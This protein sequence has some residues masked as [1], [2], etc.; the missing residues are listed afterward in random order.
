MKTKFREIFKDCV[1]PKRDVPS[2]DWQLGY[3]VGEYI[4]A[5]QLPTL[6][7]DMLKSGVVIQV[8]QDLEQ[9]WERKNKEYRALKFDT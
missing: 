6:S 9:E 5:T 7:T 3:L 8:E 1:L 2:L 4:V